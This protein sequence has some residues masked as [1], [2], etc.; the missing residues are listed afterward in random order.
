M[1]RAGRA[2]F[3]FHAIAERRP[4]EQEELDQAGEKYRDLLRDAQLPSLGGSGS[5]GGDIDGAGGG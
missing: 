5:C 4:C 2:S 1:A 3:A